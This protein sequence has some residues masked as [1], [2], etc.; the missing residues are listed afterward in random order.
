MHKILFLL[1]LTC[2]FSN[3]IRLEL[4]V[5]PES[6]IY[7]AVGIS[8]PNNSIMA[9]AC[10]IGDGHLYGVYS[11]KVYPVKAWERAGIFATSKAGGAYIEDFERF[12]IIGGLSA[13]Y[14]WRKASLNFGI[15]TA[16]F[17]KSNYYRF[18]GQFY[19]GLGLEF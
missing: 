12:G 6:E 5:S 9:F 16:T 4:A 8:I 18:L 1:L 19:I 10:R 13:G 15:I 14:F 11:E 3:S 17:T 2:C 7:G